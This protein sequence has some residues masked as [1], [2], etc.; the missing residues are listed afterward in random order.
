MR[1]LG[2]VEVDHIVRAGLLEDLTDAGGRLVLDIGVLV[3]ADE[4]VPRVHVQ[5]TRLVARLVRGRRGAQ[6]AAVAAREPIGQGG[7]EVGVGDQL[8]PSLQDATAVVQGA[9]LGVLAHREGRG[10]RVHGRR[11]GERADLVEAVVGHGRHIGVALERLI[12]VDVEA[13]L[14]PRSTNRVGHLLEVGHPVR[15]AGVPAEVADAP[16][17][18][19]VG[20]QDHAE[21]APLRP[22]DVLADVVGR[23]AHPQVGVLL[24]RRAAVRGARGHPEVALHDLHRVQERLLRP[25]AAEQHGGSAHE[26]DARIGR[27]PQHHVVL[28]LLHL[29]VGLDIAPAQADAERIVV[30][31]VD[32]A[33]KIGQPLE[34]ERQQVEAVDGLADQLHELDG[35]IVGLLRHL[36]RRRHL[37]LAEFERQLS[38][39][40][41]HAGRGERLL[42]AMHHRHMPP[43]GGPRIVRV[44]WL[45][46]HRAHDPVDA[47]GQA[48]RARLKHHIRTRRRARQC[49]GGQANQGEL[50]SRGHDG[51]PNRRPSAGGRKA[52]VPMLPIVRICVWAA[53]GDWPSEHH[54]R[55]RISVEYGPCLWESAPSLANR[56]RRRARRRSRFGWSQASGSRTRTTT[57][58]RTIGNP[59]GP[60]PQTGA[61]LGS[62]AG[63]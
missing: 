48:Q 33:S 8:L 42:A 35:H 1:V 22:L 62:P 29:R 55:Q 32:P 19:G 24:D 18:C 11:E 37:G 7:G 47:D 17:E 56:A 40:E 57:R 50:G 52:S 12:V 31:H 34:R 44:A 23:G 63:A 9:A 28:P 59:F 25:R 51:L 14:Q 38:L 16:R 49:D 46:H 26:P 54:N 20:E 5:Q 43:V 6:V 41:S 39:L 10:L 53:S 36:A 13:E 15:V 2:A 30:G 61:M 3:V 27:R 60:L 58:T 45:R 4:D 21:A